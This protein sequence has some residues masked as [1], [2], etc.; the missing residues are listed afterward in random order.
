MYPNP[1]EEKEAIARIV[2][3][4]ID[5]NDS[6]FRE[7]GEVTDIS[8][9]TYASWANGRHKPSTM[10]LTNELNEVKARTPAWVYGMFREILDVL[11]R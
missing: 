9:Q 1:T 8:H 7:L 5:E 6:S 10:T 11:Y 2:N 4:Y 3:R